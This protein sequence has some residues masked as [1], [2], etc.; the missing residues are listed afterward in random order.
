MKLNATSLKV[1]HACSRSY[2]ERHEALFS[3]FAAQFSDLYSINQ[4]VRLNLEQF[5]CLW[6]LKVECRFKNS[7]MSR[8]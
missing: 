2:K 8:T 3:E 7:N 4:Q 1:I 5:C 6:P